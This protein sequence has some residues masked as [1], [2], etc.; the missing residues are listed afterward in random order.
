M[1]SLDTSFLLALAG[2]ILGA[3]SMVLHVLAPRTKNT[4]DDR[5]RDDIDEVL[6]FLRGRPPVDGGSVAAAAPAQPP[7]TPPVAAAMML[8]VALAAMCAGGAALGACSSV[9]RAAVASAVWDC[10]AP[11]RAQAIQVLTPLVDSVIIAAATADGSKI[12]T[13]AI[14]AALGKANLLT[15]AGAILTCA[16]ASSFAALAH[17]A[18]ISGL[19]SSPSSSTPIIAPAALRQSFD[20]LRA[21]QF[22]GATFK[23]AS[24]EI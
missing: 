7:S 2:A 21:A 23:T 5:L 13:S 8:A 12:D 16:V 4:V 18:P 11:E 15:E 22:P 17:P 1:S 9:Q 6:A 20:E 19:A 24:G 10:T 3:A 14:R